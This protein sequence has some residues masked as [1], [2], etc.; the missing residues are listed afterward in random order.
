M[1][2]S[3]CF[4][5]SW[6]GYIICCCLFASIAARFG[7][8]SG[9]GLNFVKMLVIVRVRFIKLNLFIFPPKLLKLS[10]RSDNEYGKYFNKLH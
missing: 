1:F 10:D 3:V 9:I 8:M 5:F 2:I 6:M 7:A 4:L